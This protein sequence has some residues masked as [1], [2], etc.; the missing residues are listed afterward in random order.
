MNGGS[1][2]GDDGG[3]SNGGSDDGDDGSSNGGSDDDG[4]DIWLTPVKL[5]Q[6]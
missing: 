5:S 1:N 2:D 6:P 4:G 3:S